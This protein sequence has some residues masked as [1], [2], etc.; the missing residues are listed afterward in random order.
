MW[1]IKLDVNNW[2]WI[3][4]WLSVCFIFTTT[5]EL[6]PY[7]LPLINTHTHTLTYIYQPLSNLPTKSSNMFTVLFFASLMLLSVLTEGA[8]VIRGQEHICGQCICYTADTIQCDG[9]HVT[10]F[11]TLPP[12]RI[13]EI[14]V[15]YIARTAMT[16]LPNITCPLYSRLEETFVYDNYFIPCS[17]V[18]QQP[19]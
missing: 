17:T 4:L 2:P 7:H 8:E 18:S 13:Q 9:L 16:T 12:S 6:S 15:I 3:C 19:F 5:F 10:T 14:E 11:P 1:P